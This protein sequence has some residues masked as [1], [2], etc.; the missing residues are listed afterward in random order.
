MFAIDILLPVSLVFAMIATK[1]FLIRSNALV[2]F[3]SLGYTKTDVLKPFVYL[4][5]LILTIFVLLH[6]TS[7]SRANEYAINIK[8]TSQ[9]LKPTTDLFFTYENKYIYFG[10]LQPLTQIASDIR[11]F[12]LD[13]YNL[14]SVLVASKAKFIDDYW[15][16]E[17]AN[18]ISKPKDIDF[19]S[20]GISIVDKENI[21][22]LKGFKPKILDQVYEGKVNFSIIDAIDALKLL[23]DQNINTDRIKSALFKIFVYPLFVPSMVII[24]FFFVPISQRF[25]NVSLFSFGA[26]LATLLIWGILFTMIE[27]SNTKVVSPEVGI[28]LPVLVLF[29]ISIFLWR[30]QHK[31]SE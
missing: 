6:A 23:N 25:L 11:I 17:S 21:K 2:A 3:Y 5:S 19:K 27:L 8:N 30:A 20:A 4:S 12:E 13:K 24:I 7:F 28:A 31:K 29:S 1:I 26:L 18:L 15:H 22:I 9:Y 10:K 14:K 16:I